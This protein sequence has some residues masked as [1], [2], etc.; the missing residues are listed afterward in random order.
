MGQLKTTFQITMISTILILIMA[1]VNLVK[2]Q[3]TTPCTT[4]MITNFTQCANFITGSSSN[5]LTPSSSCCDSLRS[6]ISDSIDCACLVISAN[7]PIPLPINSLL[8][9]LLPKVCNINELPLQCKASG[10]PLPAPGPAVLGSNNQPLPP[11]AESPLSPQ[12]SETSNSEASQPA[13]APH[14]AKSKTKKKHKHSRKIQEY[15][16]H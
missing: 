9:S 12:A 11:I 10:S 14:A 15:S 1:S 2:G 3:I 6:L 13:L 7:A 5:G 4:S 16:Y 8:S